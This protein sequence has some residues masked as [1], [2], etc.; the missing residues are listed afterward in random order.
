MNATQETSREAYYVGRFSGLIARIEA[1]VL[2]DVIDHPGT[3]QKE[4]AIRLGDRSTRSVTPR[5]APLVRMGLLRTGTKRKCSC[6]QRNAITYYPTFA[7]EIEDN[8]SKRSI[9]DQG[10]EI[11]INTL[12][13]LCFSGSLFACGA[14]AKIKKIRNELS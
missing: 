1:E 4:S 9:N 10:L 14:I 8:R 6:S 12:S 3:T 11:A 5:F 13:E 2:Q 7:K